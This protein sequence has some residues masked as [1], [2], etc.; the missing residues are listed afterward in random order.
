MYG[1][2]AARFVSLVAAWGEDYHAS[3]A[4]LLAGEQRDGTSSRLF[5]DAEARVLISSAT[6]GK[7]AGRP[8]ASDIVA[9]SSGCA[10]AFDGRLHGLPGGSP[11]ETDIII[12]AYLRWGIDCGAH[13]QGEYSFVLWDQLRRRLVVA[14]MGSGR[15]GLAYFF[16]GRSFAATSRVVSLLRHSRVDRRWNQVYFAHILGDL[17][18]MAPGTTAF[19]QIRRTRPGYAL[20]LENGELSERAFTTRTSKIQPRHAVGAHEQFWDL[21]RDSTHVRFDGPAATCVSLSGGL[22]SSLIGASLAADC[23][24][25]HAFSLV[26]KTSS[27]S[28]EDRGLGDFRKHFG[29]VHLHAVAFE[30]CYVATGHATALPI[31]DDPLIDGDPMRVAYVRLASAMR[32]LHFQSVLDGEGADELF[33]M[34]RRFNDLTVG[35]QWTILTKTVETHARRRALLWRGLV[36]PRLPR[37]A[38]SLWAR[39]ERRRR[40]AR[41]PWLRNEFWKSSAT[42]E[43]QDGAA[44]W[45]RISSSSAALMQLLENP[46]SLGSRTWR[47]LLGSVLGIEF[48]SPM[49]DSRIV[50]FAA[51]LPAEFNWE[52]GPSKPF[53]R[54]VARGR[55]PP[56][57]IAREKDLSVYRRMRDRALCAAQLESSSLPAIFQASNIVANHVDFRIVDEFLTRMVLQM[58]LSDRVADP[59]YR[60]I[61][62]ARWAAAIG[63]EYGVSA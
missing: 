11:I 32:D 21:L 50:H 56:S 31:A 15:H 28:S 37:W 22:D 13:V 51:N 4:Q 19:G 33:W 6:T 5:H 61:T 60:L 46:M 54:R 1:R 53:L 30:D 57:L 14:S 36:V 58:P 63:A 29:N 24:E 49:L 2:Q 41:P 48:R 3:C 42:L 35:H 10:L 9:V 20:V 55:L 17:A 7:L 47:H 23:D 52:S 38:Q 44:S 62:T 39:R 8:P 12:E 34:A 45:E 18:G 27:K 59:L 26:G 16:D 40:I 43:A 25:Y